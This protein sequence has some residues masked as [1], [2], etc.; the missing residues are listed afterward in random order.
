MLGS[1]DTTSTVVERLLVVSVIVSVPVVE[2]VATV[3]VMEVAEFTT[4]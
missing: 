1:R 3:T 2:P 4:L